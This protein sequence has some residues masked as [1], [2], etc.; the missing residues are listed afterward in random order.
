MNFNDTDFTFPGPECWRHLAERRAVLKEQAE[1]DK[2]HALPAM[3]ADDEAGDCEDETGPLWFQLIERHPG[4][5]AVI[6]TVIGMTP[7]FWA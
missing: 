4:T 7:Y 2:A 3:D 6:A 5:I 1:A